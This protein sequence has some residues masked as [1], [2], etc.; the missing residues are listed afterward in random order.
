MTGKVEGTKCEGQKSGFFYFQCRWEYGT[1]DLETKAFSI[2]VK[3]LRTMISFQKIY[4]MPCDNDTWAS[5]ERVWS[6]PDVVSLSATIKLN[7]MICHPFPHQM[8]PIFDSDPKAL[9]Y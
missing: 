9:S 1:I 7:A 4:F 3:T 2:T 8:K 5:V 6:C